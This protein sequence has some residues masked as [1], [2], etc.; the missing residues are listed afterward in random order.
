[1]S[2]KLWCGAEFRITVTTTGFSNFG[3]HFETSLNHNGPLEAMNPDSNFTVPVGVDS[4]NPYSNLTK[5]GA[6]WNETLPLGTQEL[7]LR[8]PAVL[9]TDWAAFL[10]LLGWS[11]ILAHRVA[12]FTGGDVPRMGIYFFG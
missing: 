7:L 5:A 4:V 12:S 11:I 1:L 10:I 8:H 9:V 2:W 6:S 3:L